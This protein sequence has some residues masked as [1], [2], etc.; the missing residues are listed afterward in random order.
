MIQEQLNDTPLV[1]TTREHFLKKIKEGSSIYPHYPQHINEVKKWAFKIL[2]Y[3]PEADAE[4]V[5]LSV[6]LHD[7]GQADGDYKADHAIKSEAETINFLSKEGYPQDKIQ[8]VAHCV[9]AHRCKDIQPNSI[10]AKI[11]AAADSASH[12]T[13]IPYIV[14]INQSHLT[15]KDV[16]EKLERDFRDTNNYLPQ[17]LKPQIEQLYASWKSLLEVIPKAE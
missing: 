4:I 6:W 1:E 3:Y 13:D 12:M 15:R 7:I 11:L 5:L 14:M 8:R 10:E 16:L 17:Q 9:R 2:P